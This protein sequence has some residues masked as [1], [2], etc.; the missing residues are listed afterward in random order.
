M[1]R[2]VIIS[3]EKLLRMLIESNEIDCNIH[4]V[5]LKLGVSRGTIRNMFRKLLND[6]KIRERRR[7]SNLRLYEVV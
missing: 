4:S 3:T 5:A 2:P 7:L 1:G 6:G